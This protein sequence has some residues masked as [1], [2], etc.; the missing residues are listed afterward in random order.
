MW[1]KDLKR[2][3]ALALSVMLAVN[4][5]QGNI[6][7]ARAEKKIGVTVVSQDSVA[8]EFEAD[9]NVE[10]EQEIDAE[11]TSTPG[12]SV[13]KFV[14]STSNDNGVTW[15]QVT[16]GTKLQ[17]GAKLQIEFDWKLSNTA[18]EDTYVVDLGEDTVNI[19]F[20]N[21]PWQDYYVDGKK[22][23][24]FRVQDNQFEM[25]ITD[26]EYKAAAEGRSGGFKMN[27]NVN[28]SDNTKKYNDPYEIGLKTNPISVILDDGVPDSKV[29]SYKSLNG[30]VIRSGD[31][32]YQKY[33]VVIKAENQLIKDLVLTENP[34]NGLSNMSAIT[35]T[36]TGDILGLSS[37]YSSIA[38]LNAA[39][40]GKELAK[41]KTLKLSYTM[42]VD[43]DAYKQSPTKGYGNE[44][45]IA[46]KSNHD[47]AKNEN[48]SISYIN[49]KKPEIHKSGETNEAGTQI[50]WIAKIKLGD[51]TS[52]NSANT[53]S[54][55]LKAELNAIISAFKDEIPAGCTQ[56]QLSL[57]DAQVSWNA[58]ENAYVLQYTT[59]ITTEYQNKVTQTP[60]TNKISYKVGENEYKAD[61][62]AYTKGKAWISKEVVAAS[63][64]AA[65]QTIKWNVTLNTIPSGITD[66]KLKDFN[67]YNGIAHAWPKSQ[68]NHRVLHIKYG[69]TEVVRDG[70]LVAANGIATAYE[71]GELTFADEF[72]SSKASQ[73]ITFEITS[74]LET[75]PANNVVFYNKANLSY[76]KGGNDE[77]CSA[78]AQWEHATYV[79]KNGD[80]KPAEYAIDY[81]LKANFKH[82][83]DPGTKSLPTP[84]QTVTM[85]DT[86]DSGMEID[87]SS[88]SGYIYGGW[89]N[90]KEIPADSIGKTIDKV[91]H[92]ITLSY[93]FTEADNEALQ[94]RVAS[95]D[96]AN[97]GAKFYVGFK[98]KAKVKDKTA[99]IQGGVPQTF[100]N[101]VSGTYGTEDLGTAKVETE[102]TPGKVI[103]KT[104]SY[105]GAGA[106]DDDIE[107]R[108]TVHYTVEV[109]PERLDLVKDSDTLEL[110]DTLS[111]GGKLFYDLSSIVVKRVETD[112]SET[113]LTAGQYSVRQGEHDYQV[114][115]NVPDST[116]LKITY[117]AKITDEA[118]KDG[119]S[120]HSSNEIEIKAI[121]KLVGGDNTSFSLADFKG[122]KWI[123][124]TNYSLDL[125]KCWSNNI[126]TAL[127]GAEF[128]LAEMTYDAVHDTMTEKAGSSKTIK[129]TDGTAVSTISGLVAD[130]V[131]VL[132]ET[133]AP[134]GYARNMQPYYFVKQVE[135][136][137]ATYGSFQ[138]HLFDAGRRIS[139]GDGEAALLKIA[140]TVTG[141]QDFD[142]VK[143]DI[144]FVITDKDDRV[145]RTIQAKDMTAEG[146]GTYSYT[147]NDLTPGDYSVEEKIAAGALI[148][149]TEYSI[150]GGTAVAGNKTSLVH[151]TAK[152]T[153][154]VDYTNKYDGGEEV[155]KILL[156]KKFGAMP[157]G[158]TAQQALENLSFEITKEHESEPAYTIAGTDLVWDSSKMAYC[159]EISNVT[160]GT[161]Q[162]EEKMTAISGYS[163]SA[164]YTVEG[165]SGSNSA[166][167]AFTVAENITDEITYKNIYARDEGGV[168]VE[169]LIDFGSTGKQWNDVK[170][171]LS[172]DIYDD[173]GVLKKTISGSELVAAGTKT[174]DGVTY[175]VYRSAT[176]NLPVGTYYTA[177][178]NSAI[179]DIAVR[180]KVTNE[181]N[182]TS[183]NGEISERFTISKDTSIGVIYKNVYSSGKVVKISKRKMTGTEELAGAK[184]AIYKGTAQADLTNENLISEWISTDTAREIGLETG[185]DYLLVETTAPKGY[186]V[187]EMMKFRV[188][189]DGSVR[190]E[191][192]HVFTDA[193][194][195]MKDKPFEVNVN[196]TDLNGTELAGAT[197]QLFEENASC[198]DAEG[199]VTNESLA[200]AQSIHSWVSQAGVLHDFS[201]AL[202]AG[203]TY[204]LVETAAPRGYAYTESLKFK[205]NENGTITAVAPSDTTAVS[206][207]NPADA[208]VK[209]SIV[210]KDSPLSVKFNK[211]T[212]VGGEEVAGAVI[213]LF[214]VNGS[215]V[216]ADGTIA[217][218]ATPADAWTSAVGSQHDF[219]PYVKAGKQY[220]LRET[221]TPHGYQKA[222]NVVFSVANDGTVTLHTDSAQ[223]AEDGT[224]L[225]KDREILGTIVITKTIEGEVT[226]EE[227]EG[228]LQFEVINKAT[229]AT[230]GTYTLAADGQYDKNAGIWKIIVSDVP[231]GKYVVKESVTDI[232]GMTLTEVTHCLNHAALDTK[233]V[234]TEE[235]TLGRA[236]VATVDY[237]NTYV[238][239]RG[240]LVI[241]KT[242]KGDVTK[243]E[244]EGALQFKVTDNKTGE[245]AT[246][247]LT[248]FTYHTTT[249]NYLL[250]LDV[251]V[252]G[253][254]VEE[255]IYDIAGHAIETVKYSVNGGEVQSGNKASAIVSKDA[256]TTVVFEDTY[257]KNKG[258]LV[259]TKT[260]K[261]DVTKEE[262]EGAL[263]FT[264]TNNDTGVS[265][266]YTLK[267]FKY[268]KKTKTWTLT[269]TQI[270]GGYTVEETVTDVKGYTLSGVK[271]TVDK[272]T[273]KKGKKATVTVTSDTTTTVAYENTYK[274]NPDTGK[275]R[276]TKMI[277][278]DAPRKK[279]ADYIEFTV[280]NQKT[281]KAKK[282]ALSEFTYDSENKVFYLDIAANVGTYTVTETSTK[283]PGFELASVTIKVNGGT[284]ENDVSA[285]VNVV[286]DK[287]QRVLFTDS[288]KKT[289]SNTTTITTTSSTTTSTGTT[290]TTTT[291]V[292]KTGDD[293]PVGMWIALLLAGFAGIIGCIVVWRKKQGD[294]GEAKR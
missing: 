218:T 193:T 6:W 111:A 88:I 271:Y 55:S 72:I 257:T 172:F 236:D 184:L 50:T 182:N 249:G 208:T 120:F 216:K 228:A 183:R 281:K 114:V 168:Y 85:T 65:A 252:G 16:D 24:Q 260:I 186:A 294:V 105:T 130:R 215:T 106:P 15:T 203:K 234:T 57:A 66:V 223:K 289:G 79:E 246:Y 46:Y 204:W 209:N 96:L 44:V 32:L 264:I 128:R 84:L 58:G 189:T 282:Y 192:G 87:E 226:K 196:K 102:L 233:G 73:T 52:H 77:N 265:Q 244:A 138:V 200:S 263:Q 185:K 250:E 36:D 107:T 13:E 160:T 34:Q 188:G 25:N 53:D 190:D 22:V 238:S 197:I 157:T 278:D 4:V 62:T 288:Y 198:L 64:D 258:T 267:D 137:G 43:Q 262:A 7:E 119:T 9:A 113:T 101:E 136:V 42:E 175:N 2:G 245:S 153:K 97:S 255:T 149:T 124:S 176:V 241:T 290:T 259:I 210:L 11:Q 23:A 242:I 220:V 171:T 284:E 41:D 272:N 269:L 112:S 71:N 159:K 268:D 232:A 274:T 180:I 287:R 56:T 86:Y 98:Y 254:T 110:V 81:E 199:K 273:T 207:G 217:V 100:R 206:S 205:V 170:G 21:L 129:I 19:G 156:M 292:I 148:P 28:L 165:V 261:G 108:R 162:V 164:T 166:P 126:M 147:I 283:I 279:A 270:P 293:A 276:I 70:A 133:K 141:G 92:K 139:Y 35:V 202:T 1:K 54:D 178:I 10:T 59:D 48:A 74:K 179:I 78:G 103:D 99:F 12:I 144:S 61:A 60:I 125:Y 49:I 135:S 230:Y 109:N 95:V 75:K 80:P 191:N 142:S 140:K 26:A 30:N 214:E 229:N 121:G 275:I 3:L 235:F 286:K 91:N 174:V 212:L 277:A 5:F 131:Y 251:K 63:Y 29:S 145:V 31:K 225:M 239:Q 89:Y 83:I 221:T 161:Y 291:G 27:G 155:G 211:I 117:Q 163:V 90:L 237:K 222:E 40:A 39:L 151:L 14:V 17:D 127:P 115:L 227:A 118:F 33:D 266:K 195:I 67:E 167:V 213:E 194:V 243:E 247:K 152:Q 158:L 76:K 20:T 82:L 240:K 253:Y 68:G 154:R 146:D 169:K 94:E 173:A 134:D 219:G 177:E 51:F 122:S 201:S 256:V 280:T 104:G 285:T 224:I 38:A 93:T 18:S 37:S 123:T 143:D 132:Y 47:I 69:T 181:V 45:Q 231:L 150:A 8:E 187:H 116:Y 248:D